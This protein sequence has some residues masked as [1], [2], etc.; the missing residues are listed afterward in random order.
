MEN[1][2]CNRVVNQKSSNHGLV[3]EGGVVA[4]FFPCRAVRVMNTV[5]KQ[6]GYRPSIEATKFF[7]FSSD[8]IGMRDVSPEK[9]N[10]I[11]I[12]VYPKKHFDLC[13]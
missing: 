9:S 2:I 1:K 5:L 10:G 11:N 8:K 3:E 13:D 12:D 4:N 6:L 7:K